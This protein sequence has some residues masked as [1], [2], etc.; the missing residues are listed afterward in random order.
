MREE[1]NPPADAF[2]VAEQVALVEICA[3]RD[4]RVAEWDEVVSEREA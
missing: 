4:A 2:D 1:A 3:A